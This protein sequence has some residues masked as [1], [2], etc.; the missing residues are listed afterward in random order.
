MIYLLIF[1]F[2]TITPITLKELQS[3]H[4][5]DY[6]YYQIEKH[7]SIFKNIADSRF[8]LAGT[9]LGVG[10]YQ[11]IK[12]KNMPLLEK[13]PQLLIPTSAGYL[14]ERCIEFFGKREERNAKKN[15]TNNYSILKNCF[16]ILEKEEKIEEKIEESYFLEAYDCN[17]KEITEKTYDKISEILFEKKNF[18]PARIKIAKEEAAKKAK[19]EKE[20]KAKKLQEKKEKEEKIEK[21]EKARLEKKEKEEKIEAELEKRKKELHELEIKQKKEALKKAELEKEKAEA[22][23]AEKNIIKIFNFETYNIEREVR[24]FYGWGKYIEEK[25]AAIT[26]KIY[27][28]EAIKENTILYGPPGCGKTSYVENVTKAIATQLKKDV[29]FYNIKNADLKT[30]TQNS[31]AAHINQLFEQVYEKA[32]N[33]PVVL[34][35]DEF[36]GI[37]TKR[38][39]IDK[40]KENKIDHQN[41]DITAILLQK[42]EEAAG[43]KNILI[44]AATNHIENMDDAL[45]RTGRFDYKIHIGKPNVDMR[46][47]IIKNLFVEVTD[48]ELSLFLHLTSNQTS[49][50]VADTVKKYLDYKKKSQKIEEKDNRIESFV[51]EALI[52]QNKRSHKE[53][54]TKLIATWISEAIKENSIRALIEE[55]QKNP[56]VVS[57]REI[58]DQEIY[59]SV[60]C[61]IKDIVSKENINVSEKEKI[62]ETLQHLCHLVELKGL[63]RRFNE[64]DESFKLLFKISE[65]IKNKQDNTDEQ[66]FKIQEAQKKTNEQLKEL[67]VGANKFLEEYKKQKNEIEKINNHVRFISSTLAELDKK[68]L[69]KE[70]AGQLKAL[71]F[72]M[73]VDIEALIKNAFVQNQKEI[74]EKINKLQNAVNT[75]NTFEQIKTLNSKIENICNET[76]KELIAKAMENKVLLNIIFITTKEK[77]NFFIEKT[78]NIEWLNNKE[79]E[80]EKIKKFILLITTAYDYN[81]YVYFLSKIFY[82]ENEITVQGDSLTTAKNYIE[83]VSNA[84]EKFDY[85]SE[86]KKKII[87]VDNELSTNICH[88]P[89]STEQVWKNL[90]NANNYYQQNS[91]KSNLTSLNENIS[92]KWNTIEELENFNVFITSCIYLSGSGQTE[93]LS[94]QTEILTEHGGYV[95][96]IKDNLSRTDTNKIKEIIPDFALNDL[97]SELLL[98]SSYN[99]ATNRLKHRIKFNIEWVL[100]NAK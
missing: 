1:I 47:D 94:G 13:L 24:A 76:Q 44:F 28:K 85:L 9:L 61:N 84:C 49:V 60:K 14:G 57:I 29:I 87:L 50:E 10:I 86:L 40:E 81:E 90:L 7:G 100:K 26:K 32:E 79:E 21:I 17:Y 89:T 39:R 45:I 12:Y 2:V 72:T 27:N 33:G 73:L 5:N 41:N 92:K 18:Y 83:R 99:K 46:K 82:G 63:P 69:T 68:T 78:K 70:I 53:I 35:F 88:P 55:E 96:Y 8:L 75:I 22:E 11:H 67:I 4:K 36:D 52:A 30:K 65:E 66:L 6:T 58:Q 56:V 80:K 71:M 23:L 62:L 77:E 91:L 51:S 74:I 38:E 19:L 25:A 97:K 37:S 59:P 48:K 34:F 20:A 42:I 15:S 3:K 54:D 43:K 31:A 16:E 64:I 93:I 98:S 95:N